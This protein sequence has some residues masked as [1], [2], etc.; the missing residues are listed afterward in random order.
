MKILHVSTPTSWRGGEQQ[1]AF[2]A[3]GLHSL[4]IDQVVLCPI[5]SAL[6]VRLLDQ[7]IPVTTFETKGFLGI[8]LAKKISELSKAAE[9]THIHCHDS[10][11]HTAAIMYN[12]FLGKT[13][14]VIV[15]RRVAFPISKSPL[16]N[17]KYNHPSVKHII[18]VSEIVREIT[19]PKISDTSILSVIY[20]GIDIEKYSKKSPQKKL[21]TELGLEKNTILI[22]NLS[23]LS[24]SKDFPTYLSVAS[25]VCKKFPTAKFI[26]AGD[27]PE[28]STI[29]KLIQK[30]N[31]QEKVFLLGFR[32][33]VVDV[34]QSL[35]IFLFTSTIEGLGTVVLEAFAAGVPVVATRAGGI[36]EMVEDEVTGLLAETGD[37]EALAKAVLSLIESPELRENLTYASL[38]K[39]KSFTYQE[40]A[41]QT[42]EIYEKRLETK[43]IEREAKG[44]RGEG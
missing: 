16:S 3:S 11:A 25:D 15:S 6:S 22:G 37:A 41:A 5:D 13:I 44:V 39:V 35:D 14:P 32:E 17:W 20:D 26:I 10:H 23:A 2:L 42:L 30:L 8:N 43:G 21:F 33:D 36:P 12:Q 28:K 19:A 9:F 31:L 27:G 38:E 24:K 34:L 4:S 7:D 29:E 18:C 40:T 1:V